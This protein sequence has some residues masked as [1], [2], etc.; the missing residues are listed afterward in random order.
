MGHG[1]L[2]LCFLVLSLCQPCADN[3][4]PFGSKCYLFQHF[5]YYSN[6]RTWQGSI[7]DCRQ[8]NAHLLLI[9]SQEEQVNIIH[10]SSRV[11]SPHRC[12][13]TYIRFSSNLFYF[14]CAKQLITEIVSL[15]CQIYPLILV[16]YLVTSW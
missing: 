6:W 14:Y 10:F 8:K 7:D 9:E 4:L 15:A 1:K 11:S 5:I 2:F 13:M 12:G 3:W 16:K